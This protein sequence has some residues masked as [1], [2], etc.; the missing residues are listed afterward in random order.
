VEETKQT[1]KQTN[2]QAKIKIQNK[3]KTK[4]NK[5]NKT[6]MLYSAYMILPSPSRCLKSNLRERELHF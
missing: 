6:E 1:N 3:T 2:K 4:Q 5:L